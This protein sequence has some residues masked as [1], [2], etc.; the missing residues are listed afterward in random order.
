MPAIKV[1]V[2]IVGGGGC[3]LT[4][5]IFLSALGVDHLVV[6]RHPG[7]S[8]LPR[9]VTWNVVLLI[10][11]LPVFL[12][13]ALLP[14]LGRALPRADGTGP[15]PLF[16]RHGYKS[17]QMVAQTAITRISTNRWSLVRS[18]RGSGT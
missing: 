12:T 16:A 9:A 10:A 4:S 17:A 5:S 2:L 13:L 1:P 6:E 11:C 3:G 7:T 15:R 8:V 18:R 14:A